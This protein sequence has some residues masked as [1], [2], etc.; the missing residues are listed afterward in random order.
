M[1]LYI[2]SKKFQNLF[3]PQETDT[4]IGNVGQR[5]KLIIEFEAD[6]RFTS[7]DTNKINVVNG[8]E[9]TRGSGS[10][11]ADGFGVGDAVNIIALYFVGGNAGSIN[12][13]LTII[14][15]SEN[16]LIVQNSSGLNPNL[17]TGLYPQPQF[18]DLGDFFSQMSVVKAVDFQGCDFKFNLAPNSVINS[19]S[20]NSLIDGTAQ[21][22]RVDSINVASSTPLPF[23]KLYDKSGSEETSTV[24]FGRGI[25]SDGKHRF[26][27]E[28]TFDIWG[29][30]E[31][32]EN[33]DVN[34]L[35]PPS[36]FEF[37]ESLFDWIE[38]TLLPDYNDVNQ[39]VQLD[40]KLAAKKGN[41]GWINENYNGLPCP[42]KL[43]SKSYL[44]SQGSNIS[45]LN[46][47]GNTTFT[48]TIQHPNWN[49]ANTKFKV[50]FFYVPSLSEQY[51]NK[52]DFSNFDNLLHSSH[53][54]DT[55][56][57]VGLNSGIVQGREN[58]FGARMDMGDITVTPVPNVGF[59]ITGTFI[60]NSNLSAYLNT[61][62]EDNQRFFIMGTSCD[63]TLNTNI[64][65]LSNFV[66]DG[67][68]FICE[69][70]DAGPYRVNNQFFEVPFDFDDIESSPLIAWV[71]DEIKVRNEIRVENANE[72]LE[73]VELRLEVENISTGERF[74]VDNYFIDTSNTI[75]Y[76]VVNGVQQINLD[77]TRGWKFAPNME[78]NY[79]KL[80]RYVQGDGNGLV[81]YELLFGFQ[82]RWED[83][84]QNLTVSTDFF[85][86]N[87][88]FNG[89][90]QDLAP[91]DDITNWRVRHT[92]YCRVNV[93]GES[94]LFRNAFTFEVNDY[95]YNEN[96][97]EG[98][99]FHYDASLNSNLELGV[100]PNG[101]KQNGISADEITYVQA[102][103][104]NLTGS[105]DPDDYVGCIRIE[106]YQNGSLVGKRR[107]FTHKPSEADN[108]LIPIQGEQFCKIY[109]Q[110]NNDEI[111]LECL[112]DPSK[113]NSS[114]NEYL[115][116]SRI[117]C[118]NVPLVLTR[119]NDTGTYT[120]NF[121]RSY[122]RNVL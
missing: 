37:Q 87:E 96:I 73:S 38:I 76:P 74:F 30:F 82:V 42:F 93:D 118:K 88:L 103:H 29:L 14:S 61:L 70:E 109:Q 44:N 84:I 65:P 21:Q 108:P 111:I 48:Y 102:V 1:P 22:Y 81:C 90:N 101:E 45:G 98:E 64:T 107:L 121:S 53:G 18:E 71:E 7:S 85:N 23:T 41:V 17:Q 116:S 80:C 99:I 32:S 49:D 20:I 46:K 54:Q 105:V 106:E 122:R 28:H 11:I 115:I 47:C 69:E 59:Q 3:R 91:K 119:P 12:Q 75:N 117:W 39:G 67:G 120:S 78:E 62:E 35:E 13:S 24:I 83:Y 27:I 86:S 25:N 5:T 95:E 15:I 9:L 6:I 100:L 72:L 52:L 63:P 2:T 16:T 112:I 4:L 97:W 10:W 89:F 26:T 68:Q 31:D 56:L 33:L 40:A 92:V 110:S 58:E 113:L 34:N 60:P 43:I 55:V 79:V 36:W 57:S 50:H 66:L 51:K 94:K 114:A 19:G 104:T 77:T 8:N